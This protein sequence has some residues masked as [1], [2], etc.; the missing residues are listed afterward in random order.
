M[1][2]TACPYLQKILIV[3]QCNIL[4]QVLSIFFAAQQIQEVSLPMPSS[5]LDVVCC[6][7]GCRHTS[8]DLALSRACL[9]LYGI[10]LAEQKNKTCNLLHLGLQLQK[11]SHFFFHSM[12]LEMIGGFF[13]FFPFWMESIPNVTLVVFPFDVIQLF[14][15]D[16]KKHGPMN[17][18]LSIVFTFRKNFLA[19]LKYFGLA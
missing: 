7:N 5:G 14:T 15:G 16:F 19:L 11:H 8:M 9:E 2:N 13:Y 3:S 6:Y 18:N 4:P 12:P 10:L 1:V 17:V